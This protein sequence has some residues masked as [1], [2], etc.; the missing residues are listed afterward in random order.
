MGYIIHGILYI[1]I[2]IFLGFICR[3]L[4]LYDIIH[5]ILLTTNKRYKNIHKTTIESLTS[6]IQILKNI[7]IRIY[8]WSGDIMMI[9]NINDDFVNIIQTD[10]YLYK[11][12]KKCS[13]KRICGIIMI[14]ITER[15]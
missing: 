15:N 7:G 14:M 1:L 9:K 10:D 5:I 2:G 11:I 13:N 6:T 12:Y 3:E 4:C 8:D